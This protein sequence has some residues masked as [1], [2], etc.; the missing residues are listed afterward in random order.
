MNIVLGSTKYFEEHVFLGKIRV[1]NRSIHTAPAQEP[2]TI[3]LCAL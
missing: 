3:P 2:N 1:L